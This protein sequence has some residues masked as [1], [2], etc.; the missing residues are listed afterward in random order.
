MKWAWRQV[1]PIHGFDARNAVERLLES[2]NTAKDLGRE[3]SLIAKCL[4]ESFGAHG[5]L[6]CHAGY[7]SGMRL[8]H[9]SA[10]GEIDGAVLIKATGKFAQ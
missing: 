10:E 5:D 2:S 1:S 7:R 6:I 9:K 8:I 3:S 4:D